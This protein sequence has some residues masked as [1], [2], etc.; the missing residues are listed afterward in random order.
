MKFFSF[1]N[2]GVRF[3]DAISRFPFVILFAVLCTVGFILIIHDFMDLLEAPDGRLLKFTAVTGI[4]VPM[5][6]AIKLYYES[7]QNKRN[8]LLGRGLIV[9]FLG[10]LFFS[11]SDDFVNY[12]Y[13][14]NA[15]LLGYFIA[16]AI[17]VS[18][19]PYLTK[20]S[21]K[22]FWQFNIST[23][24]SFLESALYS[25]LIYVGLVLALAAIQ[26]LFDAALY[27]EIYT[28]LFIIIAGVFHTIYFLSELKKD[29]YTEENR[30]EH[31]KIFNFFSK[32]IAIPLTIFYFA[33]L[34]AFSIKLLIQ[35]E[36]SKGWISSLI[37]GFSVSG[38]LCYLFNA[39][40]KSKEKS[41]YATFKK[42]FFPILLPMAVVLFL[43]IRVR[44]VDYGL[45]EN[46]YLGILAAL[47]LAFI[48]LY[49][50]FSKRKNIRVIPISLF[51]VTL[52]SF[53]GPTNMSYIGINSQLN[54]MEKIMSQNEILENGVLRSNLSN[55]SAEDQRQAMAI[56]RYLDNRGSLDEMSVFSSDNISLFNPE[57][58]TIALS[59]ISSNL[60][61][62][63]QYDDGYLERFPMRSYN[64][65]ETT[66]IDISEYDYNQPIE[67]WA[68]SFNRG[69][70]KMFSL[71]FD[72]DQKYIIVERK[73][74][75]ISRFDI[76]SEKDRIL[77]LSPV[78]DYLSRKNLNFNFEDEK[79]KLYMVFDEISFEKSDGQTRINSM[80]G[81]MYFKLKENE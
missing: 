68:G 60:G 65:K 72:K 15:R 32:Y 67:A 74:D 76:T 26:N 20:G 51:A 46:R 16:S 28:D 14:D 7:T 78:E 77:S 70:D 79:L 44:V 55:S 48:C 73:G 27:P 53:I 6:L 63:E 24:L 41:V 21:D 81:E 10:V 45:T 17:L 13:M 3:K 58:S 19:V 56:L 38:I 31:H 75:E 47:W 35:M 33:I 42:W 64:V 25:L 4:G 12:Y 50:I 37:L 23:F 36:W 59:E 62:T 18:F 40:L 1:V 66:S 54:R 80:N 39:Y 34:Y 61:I 9:L 2:L 71:Q 52:I 5:F 69:G 43:A 11:I 30:L 29:F 22:S 8:L 57:D 49:F